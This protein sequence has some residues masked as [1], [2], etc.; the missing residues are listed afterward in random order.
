MTEE[1]V[2]VAAQK[3][4]EGDAF[5]LSENSGRDSHSGELARAV[6]GILKIAKMVHE[7]IVFCHAAGEETSIGEGVDI[8]S[9]GVRSGPVL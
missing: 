8:L 5:F 1:F 6:D 9:D 7:S 4:H 2:D 3:V